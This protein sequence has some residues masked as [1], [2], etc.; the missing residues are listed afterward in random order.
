MPY[1]ACVIQPL[2]LTAAAKDAK[3]RDRLWDVARQVQLEHHRWCLDRN[4]ILSGLRG[5]CAV[6]IGGSPA[7]S[8]ALE[9]LSGVYT[10]RRDQMLGHG[11]HDSG[12]RSS[13]ES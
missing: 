10:D 7:G 2:G 11:I 5:F 13:T 9:K 3:T 8:A 4:Q 12:W 6:F 1:N